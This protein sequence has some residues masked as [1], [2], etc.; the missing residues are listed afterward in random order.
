MAKKLQNGSSAP[1]S[2]D[3]D[4]SLRKC[5]YEPCQKEFKPEKGAPQQEYCSVICWKRAYNIQ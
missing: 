3:P 5:K 1:V 4:N 2:V